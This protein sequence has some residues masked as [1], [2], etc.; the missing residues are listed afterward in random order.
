MSIELPE[1]RIL[2]QQLDE[3]LRGKTI[4]SYDL[5]DV[6]RMKQIGFVNKYLDDFEAIKGKTVE[7]AVSRG[8]TIRVK[9]TGSMNLLIAPEYGG[10]IT[11]LPEAGKPPKYHLK[12]GFTDGSILTTRITSMGVIYAV[13]DEHISE[14]YMYR[15]DFLAGVS[16]DEPGFTWEWF[17]DTIGSEN[18]Q[19]KGLLV[20]KDSPIIGISNATFQDVIYRAGVHPKRK[21]SE[22]SE[23]ELK[24][25]FEAIKTVT[26]ERL[27]LHG[28]SEFNDIHGV[29][30]GYKAAMGPNMKNQNCPRCG[31]A[32]QKIAHGGGGVYFCPTCQPE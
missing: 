21:V 26:S 11:Y 19:P 23:N 5:R 2:A 29:Q 15:R 31:S 8:N 9:L 6:D 7:A 22:L 20:G 25:L 12:L 4:Q 1:A 28:K 32:I 17:R 10:V 27:R 30:G 16:P 24:K 18:R 13:D 3:A 14:N